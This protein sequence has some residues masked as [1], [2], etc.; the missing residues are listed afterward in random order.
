MIDIG[1]YL[2]G[3]RIRE[4]NRLSM[5]VF[6]IKFWESSFKVYKEMVEN[7]EVI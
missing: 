6:F 4:V 5:W 3:D 2:I 1:N 7:I